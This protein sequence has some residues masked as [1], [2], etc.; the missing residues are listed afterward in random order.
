VDNNGYG[1]HP[2]YLNLEPRTGNS[3][4][5][6]H[7]VLLLNSNAGE[8]A[9]QPYGGNQ[10]GAVT[11]RFIGGVI[12][13]IM[14][15][16][17][18]PLDVAAQYSQMVGPSYMPPFWSLGFHLCRWGYNSSSG[19]ATVI[20]RNRDARIP[21]YTNLIGLPYMPPFWSLGFHICKY[22]IKNDTDLQAIISRNREAKMPYDVQWNDIDYM[23]KYKDWTYSQENYKNLPAI[24][25]DLH[26]NKQRYIIMAD[27]A[28]SSSQPAG[29]YPPFDD[30][31]QLDTFVK[32]SKGEILI[33]KVWPGET[34]FPDFFHP[35]ALPYWYKQMKGFHAKLP[36]DGLWIDMNE[37][38]SFIDGAKDGC[39]KTSKYNN[40]PYT[41]GTIDSGSLVAKTICPSAKHYL[42][43]HYNLHNMYG[44]S[45]ANV[46]RA[47]L[48]TLYGNKRSPIISRSTFVGSGRYTGHWLG[49]NDSNFKDMA[50]SIA[51]ILNF[52]LF[53]IPLIGADICGFRDQTTPELCTR[54]HQLGV[55]Y[56]FM[57][58]H[59]DIASKDQDPASFQAP[60]LDSI[61][62]ALNLRYSLLAVLYTAFFNANTKGLPIV[63]PL[64]Y[65]YPGT[66]AISYQ[67]MWNDQLLVSPVLT[68]GATSVKAFIPKD[69]FY[70]FYTGRPLIG[71]GENVT[72]EAGLD[73]IPVHIRAGSILPLL[74]PTQ[75]TDDSRNEKFIITV[76]NAPDGL[77]TGQL[78]WDDGES[79]DSIRKKLYTL[80]QFRLNKNTFTS[81]VAVQGYF[82]SQGIHA[83]QV[84]ILGI[85]KVPKIVLVN[86]GSVQFLYNPNLQTLNLPELNLDL[87]KSVNI[88]WS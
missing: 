78:Y 88:T 45:Q 84:M 81:D 31:K 71:Q 83:G 32:N 23:D 5:N 63:R 16:G 29:S 53:G 54:W 15:L 73:T 87:Q 14:L 19:L 4:P 59:A 46:T 6:A 35:S 27:P 26:K 43:E 79:N 61:R 42:S 72:L 49:D 77:A 12:D 85:P 41:P 66:E 7:G 34:A 30:G 28:I 2:F 57:R 47:A 40:P 17:G 13:M 51:G 82:P 24:V 9:L 56:P 74:P 68:Q 80:I 18:S 33:G 55:F 62:K 22:G 75:R 69:T 65:T 38:S 76:A 67:F 48:D 60:Y 3:V 36:F 8:A 70:D 25:D 86:G 21:Y 11:Y 58:N 37:P 52:N 39:P 20:K 44:W 1:S 64:F 10:M 50:F